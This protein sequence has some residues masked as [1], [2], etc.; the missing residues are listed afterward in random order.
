MY[1]TDFGDRSTKFSVNGFGHGVIDTNDCYTIFLSENR[2][3]FI[4]NRK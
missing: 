1:F 4:I 3:Q 2:G